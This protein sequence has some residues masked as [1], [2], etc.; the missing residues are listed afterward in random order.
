MRALILAAFLLV[1]CAT[2]PTPYGYEE[3]SSCPAAMDAEQKESGVVRCRAM[4]SSYAR[5]FATYDD[6]CKCRCAPQFQGGY[7]PQQKQQ[8]VPQTNQM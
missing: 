8:K 7:R 5:D 3:M 1:G 4:C 2:A 6:D